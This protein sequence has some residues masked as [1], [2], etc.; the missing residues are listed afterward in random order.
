MNLRIKFTLQTEDLPFFK[1]SLYFTR[2]GGVKGVPACF[3]YRTLDP[4]VRNNTTDCSLT[5]GDVLV[6]TEVRKRMVR[7]GDLGGPVINPELF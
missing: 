7:V 5:I 4:V 2:C 3:S 1:Q 6:S